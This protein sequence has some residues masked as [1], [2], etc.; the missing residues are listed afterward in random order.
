MHY[1]LSTQS[2]TRQ[3]LDVTVPSQRVNE[4]FARITN[5]LASTMKLPG[6]RKGKVPPQFILERFSKEVHQEVA[7]SLVRD[8][9]W[10]ASRQAGVTPISNPS[11]EKLELKQDTDAKFVAS[12]DVAPALQLPSYQNLSLTKKKRQ[13]D[14]ALLEEQLKD[15]QARSAKL[16]SVETP[17]AASLLVTCDLKVTPYRVDG[18]PEKTRSFKDQVIQIDE[19]RPLDAAL[20]GLNV[21]DTKEFTLQHPDSDPNTHFAGKSVK[22]HVVVKDIRER[23]LAEINDDFAKDAGPFENLQA[24]KDRLKQDLEEAAERDAQGRLQADLLDLLLEKTTFDIP[25]SMVA[26]QLDDYCR[27][28]SQEFSKQGMDPRR[29]NWQA[30]RN[31]RLKEAERS[32]KCG[33]L[34]KQLGDAEKVEVPE[35]AVDADIEK[36][37]ADN[38]IQLTLK[39]VKN[40]LENRGALG[41]IKGRI[42][43]EMIFKRVLELSTVQEVLLDKA[44]YDALLE[45]E[46]KQ[47]Q[48]STLHP[49]DEGESTEGA[50]ADPHAHHDHG[51]HDG[52]SH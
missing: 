39:Q 13:V 23:V 8:F 24:L 11:I 41:E 30:Y 1:T 49:F 48:A 28:F 5:R 12:F 27:E 52:H 32:V 46:R 26:M 33:Y 16:K 20:L 37:M 4:T 22:Y 47:D 45:S 35:S 10:E 38:H 31:H 9:F 2:G 21:D 34:L 15:L 17:V 44:G 50:S 43:T 18:K 3:S 51:S 25:A 14:E 7:E 29:I 6:F 19:S 42:R 40:E 36:F